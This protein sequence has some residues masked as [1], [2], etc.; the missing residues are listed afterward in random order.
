M[1]AE[2]IARNVRRL[3]R[4]TR[5]VL[6]TGV[7]GL[8]AGLATVAFQLGMNGLYGIGLLRLGETSPAVLALGSFGIVT[9]TALLV[10]WL[11]QR[12]CPQAAGSG[13]PQ[14]KVAFWKDFGHVPRRV[15]WVKFVAGIL[16]IGGGSSLGREG[17][18]VQLAGGVGANLAEWLGEP[19][20]G[21]RPAA[22]AGAAAGLA[23]AFNTPLAAITFVLEEIIGNLNSRLLG[24]VL[25][26]SV[27]G[28]LVVHGTIGDQPAFKLGGVEPP[29]WLG[30]VL[31][32][33]VAGLASW[34]GVYFQR[35]SLGLRAWVKTV[36]SVPNWLWPAL[37]AWVTWGLGVAVFW[38]TGHLGVFGLGYEDLSSALAGELGWQLAGLLLLT[39]FVATFCCYGCGGCG[40]IFSPALFLG[41]MSGVL[42]AGLIDG[43][44]GRFGVRLGLTPA[45]VVALAVVGMSACLGAVVWA[46]VTGILIVFE[47]THEFGLVPVLMIGALVSQ[48][49]SRRLNACNFYDALLE[50]DGHQIEHVR[51]PRDLLSWQQLPASA[52]ANFKPVTVTYLDPT[53]LAE[54]LERH[55]Y[56]RFPVLAAERVIGMLTRAEAEAA[57]REQRPP[58]L[59]PAVTCLPAQTI[60]ELQ[61]RLIESRTGLVVLV[62]R[63]GGRVLGLVTLHDLLRAQ[64]SVAKGAEAE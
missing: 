58:Q 8:G 20:Q 30:Y 36:R 33:V 64:D 27:L 48:M 4:Q 17:P 63:V 2:W 12:F 24:S 41:G 57:T 51:P 61:L 11:L 37:G 21:R 9:V 31:T 60:R 26:A 29:T 43:C 28:A 3:P 44:A 45:D 50:Q 25:L 34:V 38:R 15:V 62:D 23:A 47:M 16:S 35:A 39:K 7:Y 54:V 6:S 1:S 53:A 42:V 46:P 10:G 59:I 13:I 52:I 5:A 49:V 40:G 19:K 14:L 22:A 18:S 56:G 32:P 55:P